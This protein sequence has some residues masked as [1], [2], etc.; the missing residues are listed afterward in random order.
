MH[1]TIQTGLYTPN[2]FNYEHNFHHPNHNNI[3]LSNSCHHFPPPPHGHHKYKPTQSNQLHPKRPS[4]EQLRGSLT[5][6][7]QIKANNASSSSSSQSFSSRKTTRDS[8][9]DG[10]SG[11][12]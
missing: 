11:P 12:K 6:L 9:I 8:V 1:S 7:N 10:A 3:S 2:I 4:K 5:Q